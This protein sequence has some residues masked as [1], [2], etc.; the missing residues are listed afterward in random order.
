[1]SKLFGFVLLFVVII[2]AWFEANN[3]N[4]LGGK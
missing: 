1:M 3:D 2:W 4:H